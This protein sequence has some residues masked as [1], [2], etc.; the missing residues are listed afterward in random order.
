[1]KLP[2]IRETRPKETL[3]FNVKGT[4]IY[5]YNPQQIKGH[6]IKREIA[7]EAEDDTTMV[8]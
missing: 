5:A 8:L 4:K 1:M 6:I 7:M 2:H 3:H